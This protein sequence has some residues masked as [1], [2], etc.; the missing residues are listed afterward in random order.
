[1]FIL[2]AD[3]HIILEKELLDVPCAF[4]RVSFIFYRRNRNLGNIA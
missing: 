1:M 4:S 3:I 2:K